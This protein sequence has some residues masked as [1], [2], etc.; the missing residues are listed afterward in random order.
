MSI[1]ELV[2]TALSPLGFAIAYVLGKRKRIA[3]VNKAEIEVDEAR[4]KVSELEYQRYARLASRLAESD[5]QVQDLL[6]QVENLSTKL[7][8]VLTERDEIRAQLNL[9]RTIKS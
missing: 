6:K 3:D 4:L 1:N 9:Y 7:R 8:I 2:L 5:I